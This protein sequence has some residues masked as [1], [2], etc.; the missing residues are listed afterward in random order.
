M[1]KSIDELINEE[2]RAY[3]KK[4]RSENR[5]K[6]KKHNARFWEKRVTQKLKCELNSKS[7]GGE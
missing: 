7:K 3:F 1:T 5:D 4:W 6:V 2:R